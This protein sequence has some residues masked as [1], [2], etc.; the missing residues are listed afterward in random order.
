MIQ[1]KNLYD[2]K[3]Q[4]VEKNINIGI[5]IHLKRPNQHALQTKT[6]SRLTQYKLVVMNIEKHVMRKDTKIFPKLTILNC[7]G[8]V[9]H[10]KMR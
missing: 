2:F 7:V 5:L 10:L 8:E 3:E 6:V 9:L 4:H 1:G